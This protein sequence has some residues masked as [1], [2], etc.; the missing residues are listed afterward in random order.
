MLT[1][2]RVRVF[3]SRT[4]LKFKYIQLPNDPEQSTK[5]ES[6][7]IETTSRCNL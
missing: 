7:R 3:F 1:L 5:K 6:L 2:E 4:V